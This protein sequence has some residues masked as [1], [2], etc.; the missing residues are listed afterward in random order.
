MS[1]ENI[2]IYNLSINT[3]KHNGREATLNCHQ[4]PEMAVMDNRIKDS[5]P[6]TEL[7]FISYP[8]FRPS[9][10]IFIDICKIL[11]SIE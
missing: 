3:A 10:G 2:Y 7:K 5:A 6:D 4:D 1:F 11:F 8:Y 9:S